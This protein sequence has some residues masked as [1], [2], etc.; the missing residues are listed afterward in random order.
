MRGIRALAALSHFFCVL[1][2]R[3]LS[4]NVASGGIFSRDLY[5]YVIFIYKCLSP[6]QLLNV[7]SLLKSP[8]PTH[9]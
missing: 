6:V 2:G 8:F 1:S 4:L 3:D 9:L 7:G 5:F